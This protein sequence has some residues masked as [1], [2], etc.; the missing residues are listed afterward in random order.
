MDSGK[1]KNFEASPPE[2]LRKRQ[3]GD[4]RMQL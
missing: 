1:H 3:K 2:S 4:Q